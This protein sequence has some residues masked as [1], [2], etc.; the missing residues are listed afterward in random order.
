L[1][2]DLKKPKEDKS[3]HYRRSSG[4]L[5]HPTSLPGPH[6]IGDIGPRAHAWLDF[7]AEAG[8][9]LWQ[10]L[11]LG[12]TGYG[13]SPYQ[14]FSA[15]AGNPYLI[16]LEALVAEGLLQQADL[17]DLPDFPAD[18]VDYG[19]LIPW[20]Q[21]MLDLA[22]RRF[23]R[24]K[25]RRLHQDFAAFRQEQSAWLEDFALFMALKEAHGGAAWKSWDAPLRDRQRQALAEARGLHAEAVERHAFRQFI[26][27]RQWDALH[28]HARKRKIQIIGDIPI[29]VAH[30]SADVWAHPELFFLDAR[31]RPTVVAG[32]PPDYYSSTGQ[33]W[34]NPLYRWEVH[35][36]TGFAW[37]LERIR[38]VLRQVD[39]VRIDHF[40]G[41]CAY[42][43]VPGR[44]R[45]ARNG[46]WVP[47]PGKEFFQA[48]QSS[49]G[50]LP[51]IAEDLG[52]ITPDVDELRETFGLPGMKVLLFGFG[53]GYGGGP[54]GPF[55]PHNYPV[56]CVAYTGTHDND[57]VRGWYERVSPEEA[58]FYRR[59]MARDGHDVS[60]DFIRAVWGSVAVLAL[61]P[62]Q[63]LL[64]LGNEARMNYPGNPSGNWTWRLPQG[65]LNGMLQARLREMNYLYYRQGGR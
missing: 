6:G 40:R 55:L 39:I 3:M 36:A 20:K 23:I 25:R 16:S 13:D 28:K 21:R 10:V 61:A 49:L 7:L 34:G 64:S 12:P 48:I 17:A 19:R 38:A 31:G 50:D 65:A 58:D 30:D 33:L 52:V 24:S 41:F 62:M 47:A 53:V 27:F 45:T 5:L 37:W 29:F 32:V 15:F 2:S 44:A 60:W 26:F 54:D 46:R 63:D 14:C 56:H 4:I 43:E 18:R 1:K 9:S 42:W 11:P 57:T 59:Y 8:C 22:Y 35:Q 51:I